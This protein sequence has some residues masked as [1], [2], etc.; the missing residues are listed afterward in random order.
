MST[1]SRPFQWL[2]DLFTGNGS[3]GEKRLSQEQ[4][5]SYAPIWY[6]V[7][8]ISNHIGQL[9]IHFY[10]R[11]EM[12]E[13]DVM[14][15]EKAVDDSRYQLL[16]S[17]PNTYQ[18]AFTFKAQLMSHVLLWGNGRAYINRSGRNIRELIPL[19]PDRTI[20]V[21]IDGE[22]FH[23]TKPQGWD[24][25][26]LFENSSE[27]MRDVIILA[28]TDVVHIPG[29]GFDGIEGL[30]LLAVAARS[31]NAGISGDKQINTQM[32][33]GFSGKFMLEAPAGA[34]RNENDAKTFMESFN[35][36]HSG[37][38]NA[39]KV[40]LLREGIKMNS[41][42]MSNQDA[43][44]LENR[45]YQRQDA[46]LWFL[47]ESILGDDS[48]VSYNSLEQKNLGY[49]SNCLMTWVVKWE[50][51]LD[52]KLLTS[53]E[54]N[55]DT[56]Y[57]KFNTAALLRSDYK[58]T[59]D[60]LAIAIQNRILNPNEARAVLEMNPYE[61]GEYYMNPATSSGADQMGNAAEDADDENDLEDSAES[62]LVDSPN[63]KNSKAIKSHLSHLLTVEKNRLIDAS[64]SPN[65]FLAF[66]DK[67]YPKFEETLNR[68]IAQYC[69]NSK[70]AMHWCKDSRRLLMTICDNV[71]AE[72]FEAK[73]KEEIAA[74]DTR[75]NKL[76]KEVSK[77]V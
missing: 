68:G 59:I 43:Q 20:T 29:F 46:A 12:P 56:N 65:K 18:T 63:D 75:L 19:L 21:M 48:S 38:E 24:R 44:F 5:I 45:K 39:D 74:W 62:D 76:V 2:V 36:Y 30:S 73:L 57:F 70:I 66:M 52:A 34:F 42:S 40:G 4:A 28:D 7:N 31:W 55:N 32:T 67:F 58:T 50:Q 6:S 53:R 61:G 72:D 41:L 3:D 15:S 17:R 37:P 77:N 71:T 16:K 64:K 69:D 10:R 27:E 47:L 22:K 25:L 23:L 54:R 51:E 60:S 26:K 13:G 14:G 9:P 11:I 33:K 35:R 8:K 49:L 1:L